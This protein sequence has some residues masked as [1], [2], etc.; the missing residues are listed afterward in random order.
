LDESLS[1]THSEIS[2]AALTHTDCKASSKLLHD[3]LEGFSETNDEGNE[4]RIALVEPDLKIV[5]AG[6]GDVI[7]TITSDAKAVQRSMKARAARKMY[8][9]KEKPKDFKV[10]SVCMDNVRNALF[11]LVWNPYVAPLS[12]GYYKYSGDLEYQAHMIM[13]MLKLAKDTGNLTELRKL[14]RGDIRVM[15]KYHRK[16]MNAYCGRRGYSYYTSWVG[17]AEFR[18]W[19]YA[20]AKKLG[21]K[22]G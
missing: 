13:H 10:L 17:M 16:R 22:Y 14:V 3:A 21:Y 9:P 6:V 12:S 4:V 19:V 20:E 1:W 11:E 2:R 7:W 15:V 18:E 5:R 8:V